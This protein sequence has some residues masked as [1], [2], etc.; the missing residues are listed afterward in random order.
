MD[1]L[2][3]VMVQTFGVD[4]KAEASHPVSTTAETTP[5]ARDPE[6]RNDPAIRVNERGISTPA[7]QVHTGVV[8]DV[9]ETVI[10]GIRHKC[11]DCPGMT[12]SP[13]ILF[14]SYSD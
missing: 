14:K 11:L 7:L 1:D 9:C 3:R 2:D 6:S 13:S 4:Y 12:S 8:C 5:A 10:H